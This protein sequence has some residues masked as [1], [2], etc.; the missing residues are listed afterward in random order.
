MRRMAMAANMAEMR[1][2]ST[3]CR[4]PQLDRIAFGIVDS[5]E[6][7]DAFHL[8]D[9][10]HVETRLPKLLNQF[11][12]PVDAE[13]DHPLPVGR[14]IVGVRLER[15]KDRC[16]GLLIPHPM[17]AAADAQLIAIPLLERV[18]VLR[19][20]EQAANSGHRHRFSPLTK[21]A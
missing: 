16:A 5:G 13:V 9:L 19:P 20:E 21:W 3:G 17:V 8:L 6:T 10:W 1:P 2:V 4:L 14:E 11:V 15:R 7:A 18:R 12:E